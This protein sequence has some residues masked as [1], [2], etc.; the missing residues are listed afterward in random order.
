MV[1]RAA[2]PA[3]AGATE[4]EAHEKAASEDRRAHTGLAGSCADGRAEAELQEAE[5]QEAELQ[6]A[7]M[8]GVE[9]QG[10]EL[11]EVAVAAERLA[12]GRRVG[13]GTYLAAR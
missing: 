9:L 4:C 10:V 1:P 13:S 11:Q 3:A 5:L 8:Q 12:S 2:C 7:E 6:E